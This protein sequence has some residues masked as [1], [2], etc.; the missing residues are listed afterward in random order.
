MQWC[1]LVPRYDILGNKDTRTLYDEGGLD[2]V[3]EAEKQ[4]SGRR[5][6]GGLSKGPSKNAEIEVRIILN[7]RMGCKDS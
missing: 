1:R 3:K 2:L 7:R 4:G 5:G 6:G